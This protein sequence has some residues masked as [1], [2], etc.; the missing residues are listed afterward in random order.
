MRY[1]YA[2]F[3]EYCEERWELSKVRAYRLINAAAFVEKV[4][5]GLLPAPSGERFTL[6]LL[7]RLDNDGAGY[8]GVL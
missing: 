8:D 2:T 5:Q 1:N 6:P 7:E 4:T 3:E